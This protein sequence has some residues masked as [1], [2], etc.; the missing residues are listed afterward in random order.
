MGYVHCSI[1]SSDF[2]SFYESVLVD[3]KCVVFELLIVNRCF[4]CLYLLS[5]K[6]VQSLVRTAQLIH[7]QAPFLHLQLYL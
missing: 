5:P 3:G 4:S 2:V 7:L 1:Y 6:A